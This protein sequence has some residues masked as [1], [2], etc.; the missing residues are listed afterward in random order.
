LLGK[1]HP[2][3]RSYRQ[4]E[5]MINSKWSLLL[6]ALLAAPVLIGYVTSG[7]NFVLE[8]P[9]KGGWTVAEGC[10][11]LVATL[12]ASIAGLGLW[13]IG[14]IGW[15]IRNS[16]RGPGLRIQLRHPDGCGGL[17]PIGRVCLDHALVLA[18]PGALL[19]FWI[20]Q[21]A[22]L[23]NRDP[24]T[25]VH[26]QLLTVVMMVAIIA[27]LGPLWSI[28]KA[29]K[30]KALERRREIENQ[31]AIIEALERRII[32]GKPTKPT[33]V[34]RRESTDLQLRREVYWRE[35]AVPSWPIRFQSAAAFVASQ[36]VGALA[37]LVAI[38]QLLKPPASS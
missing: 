22:F 29:M 37:L 17:E 12:M 2:Y 7:T 14:W 31:T 10:E 3:D 35:S 9:R 23:G 25:V 16:G 5:D 32:R 11:V 19:A 13:R 33:R 36:V 28:H 8:G 26:I 20:L 34:L 4:L 1:A 27:L 30:E 21:G 6:A 24:N 15:F 38:A 18:V